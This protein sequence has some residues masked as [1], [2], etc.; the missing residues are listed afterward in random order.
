[1]RRELML[2]VD[3]SLF[4]DI[5]GST[6]SEALFYLA[7]TFGLQDD[8]LGA[9][10]RAVG[11]VE[12][13]GRE[14]GIEHPVQMTVGISD[15]ERL[16]AVRYSTEHQSR[17]LFVSERRRRAAQ[18]APRQPA[19]AAVH[20]RGPHRGLRAAGRP[21]RSLARDPRVDRADHPARRGRATPLPATAGR[22]RSEDHHVHTRD[23]NAGERHDVGARPGSFRRDGRR[24]DPVR[25]DHADA[26]RRLERDLGIAAIGDSSFFVNDQK[27]ILSNLN[28]W[29][30]VTL[31]LGAVQMLAAYS[32]WAGNQF[33]RW[34]GIGVAGLS[35]IGALMSLPAYPFWSLAIF[36]VD[37]LVIYGRP[38][39]RPA[40]GALTTRRTRADGRPGRRRRR[41]R[42]ASRRR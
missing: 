36:A 22:R 19:P 27:Y 18:A 15:G 23:T 17:T 11:F 38:P 9:M 12:A 7:L 39:W 28:T 8:P 14:H 6:D 41:T 13:T 30:W 1:M 20:R 24:L 21:P 34:F 40:P 37:L 16:W 33:G 26:R 25:R 31:I 32:I 42:S 2:A 29:G 4:D 10:E 35:S 5:A 3:P